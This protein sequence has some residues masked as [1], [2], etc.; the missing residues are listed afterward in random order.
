MRVR[1]RL[2]HLARCF[3]GPSTLQ[4]VSA[5]A[6]SR[7]WATSCHLVV[8]SP[9]DGNVRVSAFCCHDVAV[10][11]HVQISVCVGSFHF[12]WVDPQE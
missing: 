5:F 9:A 6:S 10:N 12:S 11:T 1:V 3:Q 4:P 8:H 7:D 2:G